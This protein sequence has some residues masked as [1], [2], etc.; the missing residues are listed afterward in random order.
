[1]YQCL[2][3]LH[4]SYKLIIDLTHLVMFYCQQNRYVQFSI[5]SDWFPFSSKQTEVVNE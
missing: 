1:M 5:Y 4:V 3:K 2:C